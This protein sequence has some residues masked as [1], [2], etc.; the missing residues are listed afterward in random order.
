MFSLP[1]N[2]IT[3]IWSGI[4]HLLVL[5]LVSCE[6]SEYR[7]NLVGHGGHN[8]HNNT[9]IR[10]ASTWIA[11]KNEEL[12][13]YKNSKFACDVSID[14]TNGDIILNYGKN[15]NTSKYGCIVDLITNVDFS[16]RFTAIL[17]NDEPLKNCLEPSDEGGYNAN[18]FA[19]GYNID[20][21]KLDDF[22]NT[23]DR[24]KRTIRIVRDDSFGGDETIILACV[25]NKCGKDPGSWSGLEM[26]WS[27]TGNNISKN[28]MIVGEPNKFTQCNNDSQVTSKQ[29]EFKFYIKS[30]RENKYKSEGDCQFD[31]KTSKEIAVCRSK[32]DDFEKIIPRSWE[33]PRNWKKEGSYLFAFY[34]LPRKAS[35][36]RSDSKN[37]NLNPPNEVKCKELKIKFSGSDYKLLVDYTPPPTKSTSSTTIPPPTTTIPNITTTPSTSSTTTTPTTKTIITTTIQAKGSKTWIVVIVVILFVFVVIAGIVLFVMMK[38]SSNDN[39]EEEE[40]EEEEG[41]GG[42]TKVGDKKSKKRKGKDKKKKKKKGDESTKSKDDGKKSNVKKG[43]DDSSNYSK[44]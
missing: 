19:F 40:D 16:L 7:P 10:M 14:E 32:N 26:A 2:P 24:N 44:I 33:L 37:C 35:I 13:N 21:K 1:I 36:T 8:V 39:D 30:D 12:K 34:L 4:P 22:Y 3:I 29:S 18:M 41:K 11:T 43:G 42:S 31:E 6:N 9:I 28:M 5:L 25:R 23:N 17:S 20:R 38:K 27:R 15:S